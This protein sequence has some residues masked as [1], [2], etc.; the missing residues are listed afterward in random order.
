MV[1]LNIVEFKDCLVIN[2]K[3]KDSGF[4]SLK[5]KPITA[6]FFLGNTKEKAN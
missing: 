3:R 1:K 5:F 4:C 6:V 2:Y